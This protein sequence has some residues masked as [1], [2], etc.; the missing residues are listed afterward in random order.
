MRSSALRRAALSGAAALPFALLARAAHA[1][2]FAEASSRGA[3]AAFLFALTA[4]FLTSLTPC[5]YP[6]VPIT[7][8][9]FGAKT[10]VSRA[11]A[12]V[13]A[14]SY[15]AGIAVMFGTLGTTFALLGKAFGT[16]LANPWVVVPLAVL[17]VAMALSMFGMFELNL[18]QG[19]QERLNRVG[20][21][22]LGGA[23]LMG[24]VGGLIAAPCTGPPL[25]GILAYV[26][27]TRDAVRGFLLMATYAAG[28]GVPFWAIAG[29]SMSLPRS[30][31]WMESV[32]SV[33]GIALLVAS[34]YYLKNVVPALARLTGTGNGFLLGCLALVALGLVAG[35]VHLSFHDK[36]AR[37]LRKGVAV[38]MVTAG[39]FALTN[40]ILTPKVAL[41]W[42]TSEPQ[43]V[44]AARASGR[45]LLI[46]FGATWC[47]PCGELDAKIFGHP[48]VARLMSEQFTLLR[49]DCTREDDDPSISAIRERYGAAGLP[50]VRVVSS[51]G[52][53]LAHLDTADITPTGF[54]KL[55]AKSVRCSTD[56]ADPR[57][58]LVDCRPFPKY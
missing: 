55:L 5:V 34:L 53:P 21:R 39:L 30:G 32:K 8:S 1:E 12:F 26:A 36:L 29:F 17:F 44:A 42:M 52:A 22:G 51:D 23:F 4:G 19:L 20:G 18:P 6:M 25:A 13:L 56:A 43:A 38:A 15:V 50:A 47:V 48:D 40:F 45:P 10:G 7:V 2:S 14:T 16:F 27:T 31:R 11:R 24:L 9:I 49:I 28:I 41:A 37:R 3:G 46:D 35:A 58:A 54:I 33:L 57:P